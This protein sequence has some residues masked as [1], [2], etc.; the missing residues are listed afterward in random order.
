[1]HTYRHKDIRNIH[2]K[3][4]T[5]PL[6]K[7]SL[8][9]TTYN[10]EG[11]KLHESQDTHLFKSLYSYT[12]KVF[13]VWFLSNNIMKIKKLISR[14]SCSTKTARGFFSN[15]HNFQKVISRSKSKQAPNNW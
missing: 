9:M 1:M 10:I 5:S 11:N 3:I 13:A 15:G 7:E 6:E 4:K 8:P 14:E 12:S 2:M